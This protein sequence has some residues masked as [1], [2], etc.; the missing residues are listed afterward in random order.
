MISLLDDGGCFLPK[1]LHS[2]YNAAG[3]FGHSKFELEP[4]RQSSRHHVRAGGTRLRIVVAAS[5]SARDRGANRWRDSWVRRA[6]GAFAHRDITPPKSVVATIDRDQD[7][8]RA[9]EALA[10]DDP[11]ALE[12]LVAK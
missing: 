11:A 7:R 8:L 6:G 12:K 1:R 3:A 9:E 5:E 4:S 2:S 10:C